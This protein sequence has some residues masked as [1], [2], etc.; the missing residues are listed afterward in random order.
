MSGEIDAARKFQ[1]VRII[2]RYLINP[3]M[4]ALVSAGLIADHALLETHGR[5]TG[6][7]RVSVVG[8][9]PDGSTLWVVSEHGRRA[10]YVANIAA[11]PK[12]R[13]RYRRRWYPAV[14]TLLPED[15]ARARLAGWR[16]QSTRNAIERFGTQ[17][18]TIR[19]DL[20]GYQGE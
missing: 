18:L 1:R 15:D 7:R 6:K 16:Q 4:R 13:V 11:Q 12:I 3:P 17:L 10:G 5:K 20:D 14:A 19:L 8:V 9:N 2:Q